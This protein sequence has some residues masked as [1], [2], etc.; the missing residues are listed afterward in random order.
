MSKKQTMKIKLF[1]PL[2]L[3]LLPGFVFCQTQKYINFGF[4]EATED[5]ELIDTLRNAASR[6]MVKSKLNQVAT[7]K[8]EDGQ[9]LKFDAKNSFNS[10]FPSF[11]YEEGGGWGDSEAKVVAPIFA[12]ESDYFYH[13]LRGVEASGVGFLYHKQNEK[14]VPI[15]VDVYED[16]YGYFLSYTYQDFLQECVFEASLT[17]EYDTMF[18]KGGIL[19]TGTNYIQD[20]RLEQII[21]DNIIQ[22]NLPVYEFETNKASEIKLS[23]NLSD[24]KMYEVISLQ[25]VKNK[26]DKMLF[27]FQDQAYYV[28]YDDYKTKVTETNFVSFLSLIEDQKIRNYEI[29]EVASDSLILLPENYSVNAKHKSAAPQ[30]INLLLNTFIKTNSFYND[31]IFNENFL[32]QIFTNAV[33]GKIDAYQL[34]NSKGFMTKNK[35][36]IEELKEWSRLETEGGV[37][38]IDFKSIHEFGLS[39]KISYNTI[40]STINSVEIDKITII[41]P[42]DYPD[43]LKGFQYPIF[44]ADWSQAKKLLDKKATKFIKK[45]LP[46]GYFEKCEIIK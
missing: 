24:Y 23:H 14:E 32:N 30:E 28:K 33:E 1:L 40:S 34:G 43:N 10:H 15:W 42:A 18:I 17:I 44:T 27:Y 6:C 8:L 11:E 26:L 5:F 21:I 7:Y 39:L 41:L 9:Y 25:Y 38:D 37:R 20:T 13:E 3:F 4:L 29:V 36:S 22:S 35:L 12:S 46:I 45:N 19:Y 16:R 31:Q 2:S